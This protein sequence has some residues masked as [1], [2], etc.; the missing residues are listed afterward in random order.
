MRILL[1]IILY[2]IHLFI[3]T[4]EIHEHAAMTT[5]III[6]QLYWLVNN[7]TFYLLTEDILQVVKGWH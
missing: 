5:I 6:I 1:R 7:N 3:A 4:N 2:D